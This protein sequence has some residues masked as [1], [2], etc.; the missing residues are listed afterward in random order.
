MNLYNYVVH[1]VY[2]FWET[3]MRIGECFEVIHHLKFY[4]T[5]VNEI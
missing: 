3:V 4:N 5:Y 2:I 1:L